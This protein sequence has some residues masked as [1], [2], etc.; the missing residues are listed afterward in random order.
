MFIVFEEKE[1]CPESE[2]VLYNA[3][4]EGSNLK[5]DSILWSES[6]REE[7]MGNEE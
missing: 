2:K 1:S 7:L 6:E 3:L 4:A 5:T